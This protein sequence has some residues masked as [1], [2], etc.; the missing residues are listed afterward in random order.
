MDFRLAVA[1]DASARPSTVTRGW[2]F[3]TASGCRVNEAFSS[4]L[5]SGWRSLNRLVT[6][7]L[8]EAVP[9]GTGR[10]AGIDSSTMQ[11]SVASVMAGSSGPLDPKS[12]SVLAKVLKTG[13]PNALAIGFAVH[14]GGGGENVHD[15][16]RAFHEVPG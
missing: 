15:C 3:A 16:R 11:L 13:A 2:P 12:P 5:I 6:R 7:T 1:Q 14:L 9:G 10:L 4:Y 8:A